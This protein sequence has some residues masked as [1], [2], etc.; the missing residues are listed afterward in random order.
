[1]DD[2]R[3]DYNLNRP[4]SSLGYLAPATYATTCTKPKL[5]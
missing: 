2:W 4:H 5:S 3:I 1:V